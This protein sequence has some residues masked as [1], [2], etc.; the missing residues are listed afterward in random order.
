M[1]LTIANAAAIRGHQ[2]NP[3]PTRGFTRTRH[4]AGHLAPGDLFRPGDDR[5]WPHTVMTVRH[6]P[7]TV[8]LTDQFGVEFS[9]SADAVIPTV[10]LDAWVL[11]GGG[12]GTP[13]VNGD[14]G[15]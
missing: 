9:Y 6:R 8:V 10:V 7:G 14:P 12:R 13:L 2:D 4:H 1:C 3:P 15:A 11:P 5:T